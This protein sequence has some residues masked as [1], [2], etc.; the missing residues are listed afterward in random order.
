MQEIYKDIKG[1]EWLYQISNLWNVK[2]LWK[3]KNIIMFPFVSNNWYFRVNFRK[4]WWK[5]KFLVHRLVCLTFLDIIEVNHKDWNK[6]NNN[7]EN[8]EWCNS[9]ENQLHNFNILWRKTAKYWQWK[10]W[11]NH[12]RSRKV[13]QY[14]KQ[15]NFIK[16]WNSLTEISNTYWMQT[17]NISKVCKWI[18]KTL[19]GFIWKYKELN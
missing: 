4:D 6:Q 17:T 8:L 18:W 1:Y 13:N 12:I 7:V 19:W 10:T 14:D 3:N 2:S 11:E 9:S 15:W 16:T 5:Q